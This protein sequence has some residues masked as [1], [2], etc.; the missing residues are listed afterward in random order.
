MGEMPYIS[1]ELLEDDHEQE[2]GPRSPG[3]AFELL[4]EEVLSSVHC[5]VDFGAPKMFFGGSG[6]PT[7]FFLNGCFVILLMVLATRVCSFSF[8]ARVDSPRR[9]MLPSVSSSIT[10]VLRVHRVWQ[11]ATR[12]AL[13]RSVLANLPRSIRNR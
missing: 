3:A 10:T 9:A 11:T 8:L 6:K 7:L 4:E 2:E 5:A 13:P 1:Q 12:L